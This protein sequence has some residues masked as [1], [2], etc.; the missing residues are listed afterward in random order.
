[1][2]PSNKHALPTLD[3][4]M[5]F[6]F[7]CGGDSHPACQKFGANK[8][9]TEQHDSYKTCQKRPL[10]NMTYTRASG[11]QHMLKPGQEPNSPLSYARSP[12]VS[13]RK[14]GIRACCFVLLTCVRIK[15]EKLQETPRSLHHHLF[16]DNQQ[17]TTTPPR[18]HVPYRFVSSQLVALALGFLCV[19]DG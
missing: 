2:S 3:F 13:G 12:R 16:P 9:C 8:C 14:L 4:T 5:Y 19:E 18:V 17:N 1:M 11:A 6:V 15:H 7:M 10:T